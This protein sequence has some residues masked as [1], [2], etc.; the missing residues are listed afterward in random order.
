MLSQCR[1]P[2]GTPAWM[3]ATGPDPV[4]ET[5]ADAYIARQIDRDYDLWVVEIESAK[6][7]LSPDCKILS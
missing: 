3:R 4:D 5:K 1:S 7:W 6:G 2:D